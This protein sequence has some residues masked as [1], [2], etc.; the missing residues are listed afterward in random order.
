MP[1][2]RGAV[3]YACTV[4]VQMDKNGLNQTL[5]TSWRSCSPH[6]FDISVAVH[7]SCKDL[8]I[9]MD[10][11]FPPHS[12]PSS[13][14]DSDP[15]NSM[16][17]RSGGVLHKSKKCDSHILH[18][19][20]EDWRRDKFKFTPMLHFLWC[21]PS[22]TRESPSIEKDRVGPTQKALT[23]S[24]TSISWIRSGWWSLWIVDQASSTQSQCCG[25]FV[26]DLCMAKS[27]LSICSGCFGMNPS[28]LDC[29]CCFVLFFF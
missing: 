5:H 15:K 26:M 20:I 6:V 18:R 10:L 14:S 1:T 25:P 27:W 19:S 21:I 23:F 9:F 13:E 4:F 22:S 3:T 24:A 2:K 16:N 11:F 12:I 29:R 17:E 8:L 28:F 7:L